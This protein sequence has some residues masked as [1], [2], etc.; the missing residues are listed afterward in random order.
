MA[1]RRS[2]L[3]R[4][5]NISSRKVDSSDQSTISTGP[6][7]TALTS[8]RGCLIYRYSQSGCKDEPSPHGISEHVRSHSS[9]ALGVAF[10][11]LLGR[12]GTTKYE[13]DV[14]CGGYLPW[15]AIARVCIYWRSVAVACGNLE[16]ATKEMI[17]PSNGAALI[18]T[19]LVTAN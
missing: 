5:L 1:L 7:P 11:G 4:P 15:V 18:D 9:L 3:R 13:D 12:H 6:Q 17:C 8:L 19:P 2:E 10:Q 16:E 14:T